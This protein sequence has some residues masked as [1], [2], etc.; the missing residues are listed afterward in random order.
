MQKDARDQKDQASTTG[1]NPYNMKELLMP[2]HMYISDPM[3]HDIIHNGATFQLAGL[4]NNSFLAESRQVRQCV[5][6]YESLGQYVLNVAKILVNLVE[7]V[8]QNV[9]CWTY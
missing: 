6:K 3:A 8:G 9:I 1:S 5:Q 4:T 2:L 7:E